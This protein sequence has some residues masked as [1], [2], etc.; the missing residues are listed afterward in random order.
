MHTAARI[1]RRI[2]RLRTKPAFAAGQRFRRI[3]PTAERTYTSAAEANAEIRGCLA[4]PQKWE[5]GRL[6]FVPSLRAV[7]IVKMRPN[8]LG[9]VAAITEVPV[10]YSQILPVFIGAV[11]LL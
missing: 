7:S 11:V 3:K 8:A 6:E 5:F 4:E 10:R 9:A 1:R 2:H